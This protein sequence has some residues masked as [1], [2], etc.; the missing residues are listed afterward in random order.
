MSAS[1]P[2]ELLSCHNCSVA[3]QIGRELASPGQFGSN[4]TRPNERESSPT[5]LEFK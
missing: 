4:S 3:T 1:W 5:Q 2:K